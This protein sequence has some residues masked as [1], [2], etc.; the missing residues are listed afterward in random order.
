MCST[1]DYLQNL[2]LNM[3]FT[4][5]KWD[6]KPS[7][8]PLL[9]LPNTTGCWIQFANRTAIYSSQQNTHGRSTAVF[10]KQQWIENDDTSLA[11]LASWEIIHPYCFRLNASINNHGRQESRKSANLLTHWKQPLLSWGCKPVISNAMW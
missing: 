7:H 2:M 6:L 3:H 8:F 9:L 11:P 5:F 4:L 1:V 10:T